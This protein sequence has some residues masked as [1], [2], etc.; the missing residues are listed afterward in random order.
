MELFEVKGIRDGYK[1]LASF[2]VLIKR[3]V[4]WEWY[5]WQKKS[6]EPTLKEREWRFIPLGVPRQDTEKEKEVEKGL[7]RIR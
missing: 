1:G 2:I 6:K 5:G 3:K 4:K 7:T